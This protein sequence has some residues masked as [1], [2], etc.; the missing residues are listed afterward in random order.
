MIYI[1]N[2][3]INIILVY[4]SELNNNIIITQYHPITNK[5]Y[6]KI[7]FNSNLL[8]KIKSTLTMKQFYPIYNNNFSKGNLELYKFGI[9]HYEIQLRLNK[10]K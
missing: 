6:Y 1:P 3:I 8:W 2:D 9:P 4:V 5:E 7:N 10:I